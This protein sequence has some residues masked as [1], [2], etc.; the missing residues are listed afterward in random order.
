MQPVGDLFGWTTVQQPWKSPSRITASDG[1]F[2]L[3]YRSTRFLTAA[4][5][6]INIRTGFCG[7]GDLT[8]QERNGPVREML[9]PASQ[10]PLLIPTIEVQIDVV[11]KEYLENQ[12]HT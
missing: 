11:H 3:P 4:P 2:N 8:H 1:V 5:A 10:T 9:Q 6:V 7:A 12:I